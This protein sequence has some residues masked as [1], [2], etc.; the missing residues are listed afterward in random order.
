M[1]I[2]KSPK[3]FTLLELLMIILII[4]VL[5]ALVIP[6]SW[7][8]KRKAKGTVCM[9]HLRQINMGIHLYSDDSGDASPTLGSA[10]ASTNI[11]TLYSGYKELMKHY[12]GLNGPSSPRDQVFACPVDTRY[13]SYVLK[14]ESPPR[15]YI[16]G[17]LHDTPIFD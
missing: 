2:N 5:A 17:S 1:T 11:A 4:A 10:A 14:D 8:S 15:R 7:N 6:P 16:R 12:V 3:G 9:S 13:P